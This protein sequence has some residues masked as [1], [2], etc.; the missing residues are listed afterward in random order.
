[1]FLDNEPVRITINVDEILSDNP[2]SIIDGMVFDDA[3]NKYHFNKNCELEKLSGE[4]I[5]YKNSFVVGARYGDLPFCGIYQWDKSLKK[6]AKIDAWDQIIVGENECVQMLSV[7]NWKSSNSLDESEMLL[8]YIPNSDDT[9][10]IGHAVHKQIVLYKHSFIVDDYSLD[11]LIED[12][13]INPIMEDKKSC[14]CTVDKYLF[15]RVYEKLFIL[16][17]KCHIEETVPLAAIKSG[18]TY[19]DKIYIRNVLIKDS[20]L[21]LPYFVVGFDGKFTK[22]LDELWVNILHPG[23]IPNLKRDKLVEKSYLKSCEVI[24]QMIFKNQL[25]LFVCDEDMIELYLNRIKE[26]SKK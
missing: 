6:F 14:V 13:K 24:A 9:F 1:M 21:N 17:E 11:N 4:I 12:L 10:S 19:R 23:I 8:L 15:K 2:T 16:K 25:S 7:P 3:I 26:E 5:N 20:H 22:S 18:V